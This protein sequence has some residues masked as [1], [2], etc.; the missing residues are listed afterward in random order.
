MLPLSVY[1]KFIMSRTSTVNEA[2]MGEVSLKKPLRCI[3][4][5]TDYILQILA[6]TANYIRAK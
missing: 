3:K 4:F 5:C 6:F 2:T 1:N